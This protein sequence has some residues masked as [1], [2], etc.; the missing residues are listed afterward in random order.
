[1]RIDQM[2]LTE[3]ARSDD[4]AVKAY[5]AD[6]SRRLKEGMDDYTNR[7]GQRPTLSHRGYVGTIEVADEAYFGRVEMGPDGEDFD[8]T[9][10]YEGDTLDELR[11]S[12]QDAVDLYLD[13]R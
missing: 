10:F 12:M 2:S 9:I 11:Q 5:L 6:I 13:G 8:G 7:Y 3:M 4:P 1:M